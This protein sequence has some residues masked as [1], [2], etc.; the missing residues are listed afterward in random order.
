MDANI[1]YDCKIVKCSEELDFELRID[2]IG[3]EKENE[4]DESNGDFNYIYKGKEYQ[5]R[6]ISIKSLRKILNELEKEGCNYLSID[7]H[8][9]HI[10]YDIYGLDVHESTQKEIDENIKKQKLEFS[11]R[12]EYLKKQSQKYLDEVTRIENIYL[13]K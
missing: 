8:S 2:V 5:N 9:D 12:I 3:K 13:N 11:K 4:I 7:Y 6:P 10:E 1:T